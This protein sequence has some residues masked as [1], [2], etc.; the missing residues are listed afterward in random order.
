MKKF[1]PFLI[2]IALICVV[3]VTNF[4]KQIV[5]KYSYGEDRAD[6]NDYFGIYYENDVP[7]ILEDTKTD[8]RAKLFGNEVYLTKEFVEDIFTDR[9]YAD[10]N[11]NLFLYTT[12]TETVKAELNGCTYTKNG[13][14]KTLSCP[15]T[16]TEDD[17]L[18]IAIDYLKLF[19]NLEYHFYD[20]PNHVQIYSTWGEKTV[21]TLKSDTA[22]RK[23]G[24]VKSLILEDVKEGDEVEILEVMDDWTKVKTSDSFIGYVENKRLSDKET[25]METPVTDV[26][27]EIFSSLNEG[28]KINLTWHNIEYRQ[29]ASALYSACAIIKEVNVISPTW[30]WLTDNEGNFESL[31]DVSYVE[32]AHNMGMEVWALIANFHSGTDVDLT[33]VLSYTS[34]REYLINNLITETV[35]YGADGINID[36]EQVPFE[37]G[38]SY[39]QFI[40]ELSLAAHE[41]GLVVSVDNYVPTEYTAHYNRKEQGRFADYLIIMGYDEHYVGSEV[42]SV[43]G[44]S[45]VKEGIEKTV[46]LVGAEKVINAVP[47]YT[48]VWKTTGDAVSSEAVD[49]MTQNEFISSNNIT[50]T[51]DAENG[52]NYGEKMIGQTLYQVWLE[53]SD[54]ITAKLNVM[55]AAGITGVASW[56]LGFETEEIWDLLEVYM[57]N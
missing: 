51:W 55:N 29:D 47:F 11:E 7:I 38:E 35:S 26:P 45:W 24:G 18:Y 32:A 30:Y 39:V 54:S 19:V 44:L 42:G 48:R 25:V 57:L 10:T 37:C 14:T 1:I 49:M 12:P 2:A 21:A 52:Q 8:F 20:N 9:F 46:S 41:A 16:V 34:K 31:G 27:E 28:K 50:T 56:R 3:V 13:E 22:V 17:T 43:A 6:L 40:R 23:L 4:G 53:D 36:F 33:E 5:N 15:V